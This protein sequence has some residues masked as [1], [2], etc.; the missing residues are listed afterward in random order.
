MNTI[1][2]ATNSSR[3]DDDTVE[4]PPP[5]PLRPEWI[6]LPQ[7]GPCP[8]TGLS[9]SK[10]HELILPREQNGFKPPV[11]SVCLAPA[12]KTKGVRLIH[13]QS[14]LDYL[15]ERSAATDSCL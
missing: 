15:Y 9:R 2:T 6:R 10:L 3:P 11:R 14:L 1:S 5:K 13:L 8:W 12:G 7:G 4:A